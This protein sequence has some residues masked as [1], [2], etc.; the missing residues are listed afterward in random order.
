VAPIVLQTLAHFSLLEDD[1]VR[2]TQT[3]TTGTLCEVKASTKNVG[4]RSSLAPL[5]V[6][7]FWTAQSLATISLIKLGALAGVRSSK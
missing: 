3:P 5:V 4:L 7:L 6:P 2:R 1:D